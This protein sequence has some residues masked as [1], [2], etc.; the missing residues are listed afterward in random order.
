M[1][2]E[3][4]LK[5]LKLITLILLLFIEKQSRVLGINIS[6]V[7]IFAGILFLFIVVKI[8]RE[9][10]SLREMFSDRRLIISYG[11]YFLGIV[12]LIIYHN[13]GNMFSIFK[14]IMS[15]IIAVMVY[16]DFYFQVNDEESWQFY[17]TIFI[18]MSC[19]VTLYGIYEVSNITYMPKRFDSYFWGISNR[20]TSRF[21]IILPMAFFLA[22]YKDRRYYVLFYIMVLGIF[23]TVS[24][25]GIVVLFVFLVFN[26]KDF[27]L[28][29]NILKTICGFSIIAAIMYA[30]GLLQSLFFRSNIL[31]KQLKYQ[32]THRINGEIVKN[33][34]DAASYSITRFTMWKRAFQEF[35]QKPLFGIGIDKYRYYYPAKSNR[36]PEINV[37][38]WILELLCEVGVAGLIVTLCLIIAFYIL[39]IRRYRYAVKYG[40]VNM[41]ILS[42]VA[43]W[44]L[45]LFLLHNL[46]E[47]SANSLMFSYGGVSTF[48]ICVLGITLGY[49]KDKKI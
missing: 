36:Q 47:A 16:F 34:G 29:K 49:K 38:N 32:A 5:W 25:G 28:R 42:L 37:H 10:I 35:I 13:T 19:F 43:F 14:Y 6:A 12:M 39:I 26:I 11:I 44:S 23:M 45:S 18:L 7:E 2:G 9:K 30:L 33:S 21:L 46:V 31:E 41:K 27:I 40:D 22:K 4:N 17:F 24:R 15:V 1:R 48:I 20:M 3:I 8:I